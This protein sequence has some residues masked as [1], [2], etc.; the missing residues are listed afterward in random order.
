[1]HIPVPR[2]IVRPVGCKFAPLLISFALAISVSV[3]AG[4]Q[5]LASVSSPTTER[6]RMHQSDQWLEVQKHLPDPAT[7]SPQ[8]LEQQADILRARRFPE[9]AMDYYKYAMDRGGNPPALLNKLGLA[10]L[11]MH[12]IQLARV[13]F[14][15]VV[16]MDKKNA[17]AWNNLGASEF[18][19]GRSSAAISDYKKAIKTSRHSAV[20]HAN[21]ANAYFESRNDSGARREIAKALELDPHVFE[22]EGTGGIAA[23]VLSSEDAARFSFE[24]A[25]MY[26]RTSMEEEMLRAL[27]K[28]AEAGMDIRHEMEHDSVLAKYAM[29]PR[30]VTVVRNAEM[31][32]ATRAPTVSPTDS[33]SKPL[34]D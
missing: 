14:Q 5:G 19:D 3:P 6:E 20:F 7:A 13:Y 9:D 34:S 10:E 4:S 12:H 8:S 16:K 23:H 17:E 27:G 31:L 15:R 29:D 21:L 32:R 33:S 1:M 25:R 22:E 2:C 26:A 24:M 18:I 11:E 28:A 30:V